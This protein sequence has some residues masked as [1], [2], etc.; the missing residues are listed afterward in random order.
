MS[1]YESYAP[2]YDA[3][4]Q[5]SFAED[6]TRHILASMP[7]PR[8][9]LDLACGTGAAAIMLAEAGARVVGVDRS[10]DM[11]RIARARAR[12]RSLPVRWVAADIR[13]LGSSPAARG[14]LRPASFDL[15][16]CLYDSLNYLGAHEDLAAVC[17]GAARLLRPGGRLVFDLNTTY[18]FDSW[19]DTDQVV[20]DSPDLLVYNRL[21]YDADQR[22]ARGRIVWFV[23]EIDRWWRGEELHEERTWDDGEVLAALDAAGLAL[24]ARRT[25]RWE[26]APAEATRVV[27]DCVRV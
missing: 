20:F 26:P 13:R 5:G 18:E 24:A 25:P 22:M 4:G 11:L 7:A 16:T 17:A 10:P 15:I 12:D 2:I 14:S 23:R 6:L 19:D 3:I 8:R 9:A 27:Y 1:I 21:S